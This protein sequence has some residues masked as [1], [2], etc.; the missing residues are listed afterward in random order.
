MELITK[1]WEY[2]RDCHYEYHNPKP[3]ACSPENRKDGCSQKK[4]FAKQILISD[5][6]HSYRLFCYI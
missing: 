2:R 1:H 5:A 6:S 4:A 3:G